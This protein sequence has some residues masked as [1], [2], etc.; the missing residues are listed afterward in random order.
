MKPLKLDYG[1]RV[2]AVVPEFCSGPGWA[3]RVIWVHIV[4]ND[5]RVRSEAIQPTDQTP[6]Q[7]ALF[8]PGAAMHDA[9]IRS[10]PT[11]DVK[12]K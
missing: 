12:R 6:E 8:A 3:N 7:I 4:A 9:L 5:G 10:V 1:E 11:R 2:I